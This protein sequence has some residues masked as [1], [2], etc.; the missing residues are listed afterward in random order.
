MNQ[1]INDKQNT[2][3]TFLLS[4]IIVA[5]LMI[6]FGFAEIVTGFT[7]KYFGLTTSQ[8]STST[9]LGF[10]L[11]LFYILSG[12]LILTKKRWAAIIAIVLLC[13]DV[14]G[15]I[16]MVIFGLYPVNTFR[17]TFGIVVG[18]VIAA[19]FSIYIYLK[20]KSFR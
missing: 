6:V 16:A 4:I 1:S 3:Q 10:A 20:L 18:T 15:R 5:L 2:R 12:V 11:G 14:L 8:I 19:Y 9:I 7:H 17:Q 13:G